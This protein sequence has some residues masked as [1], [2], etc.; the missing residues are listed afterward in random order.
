MS[1]FALSSLL[2][3]IY[4]LNV[5][6]NVLF[7]RFGKKSWGFCYRSLAILLSLFEDVSSSSGCWGKVALLWHSLGFPYNNFTRQVYTR[8]YSFYEVCS[9]NE[10]CHEK[11]GFLHMRNCAADQR[12]CFRYTDSTTPLLS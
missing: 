8:F 5:S 12:L 10:P 2:F 4:Y 9:V 7:P 6:F 1:Y 11:T 3:T